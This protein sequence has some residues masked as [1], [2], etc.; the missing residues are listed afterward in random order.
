MK[1]YLKKLSIILIGPYLMSV[2]I[3]QSGLISDRSRDLRIETEKLVKAE[4]LQ[5]KKIQVLTS[6]LGNQ[7]SVSKIIKIM[8]VM[9]KAGNGIKKIEYLDKNEYLWIQKNTDVDQKDFTLI[10]DS[11]IFNPWKIIKKIK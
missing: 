5:N 2:L 8:V 6:E 3:V 1:S 4:N 11:K 7:D 10:S 9:P